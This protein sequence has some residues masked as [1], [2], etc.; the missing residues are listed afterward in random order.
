MD[1]K[2]ILA[3]TVIV[4]ALFSCMSVASAG[5]FD[6]LMGPS[7]PA[8]QTYQFDGFTLQIPENANVTVNK[9]VEAGYNQTNYD[10][11][12]TTGDNK[13]VTTV[14]VSVARGS[15][16]VTTAEEFVYNW[17]SSGAKSLG[18]YSD[19]AVIDIN[20]VPIKIFQDLGL[21]FTYSGYMLAKHTG[22]D[23]IVISGDDLA[24]LKN[25]ADTYKKT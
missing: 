25:I 16:I 17:V 15:L 14:S 3:L 11:N 12:W 6:F 23:L 10:M 21:N 5:L 20:G 24:L 7:Q 2:K 1:I 4:L 18:N 13:N 19:W 8:N 9:T 22:S